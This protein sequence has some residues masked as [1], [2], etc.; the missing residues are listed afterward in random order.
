MFQHVVSRARDA[1]VQKVLNPQARWPGRSAS[2]EFAQ[3]PQNGFDVKIRRRRQ[4]LHS[5]HRRVGL[6]RVESPEGSG[7]SWCLLAKA[8]RLQGVA[9]PAVAAFTHKGR[10]HITTL[11]RI[12]L[13]SA[14]PLAMGSFPKALAFTLKPALHSGHSSAMLSPTAGRSS[15]GNRRWGS[16]PVQAPQNQL[17]CC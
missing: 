4:G 10:G 12:E 8:M 3:H 7:N 5:C 15:K 6:L 2:R 9:C 1:S 13:S 14:P 16:I 11:S 17:P